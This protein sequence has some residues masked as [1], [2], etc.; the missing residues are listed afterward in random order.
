M[1]IVKNMF[2]FVFRQSKHMYFHMLPKDSQVLLLQLLHVV[3]VG[4][5]VGVL[6][7]GGVVV[8]VD[9]VGVVGGIV[10]IFLRGW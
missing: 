3:F 5:V 1:L 8:V 6:G 9:V 10:V 4:D 2:S 7:G